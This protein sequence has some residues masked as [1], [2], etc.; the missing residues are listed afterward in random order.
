[1]PYN[2]QNGQTYDDTNVNDQSGSGIGISPNK[3]FILV[4]GSDDFLFVADLNGNKVGTAGCWRTPGAFT[5]AQP[6]HWD[7]SLDPSDPNNE[8]EVAVGKDVTGINDPSHY[9]GYVVKVRLKDGCVTQLTN[10]KYAR[11]SSTRDTAL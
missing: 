3:H 5:Q 7:M 6:S 11:H 8:D 2:P 1:I 9:S 4:Q 10:A